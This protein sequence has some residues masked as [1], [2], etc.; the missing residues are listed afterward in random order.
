M[1]NKVKI[2]IVGPSE[3]G[4]TV[5]AN[6]LADATESA[7]GDYHPTQG[8]RILEFEVDNVNLGGNHAVNIEVEL[9]DCSGNQRFEICW[10]AMQKD[11]NGIIFVYNLDVSSHEKELEN[12]YLHFVKGKGIR[13]KLCHIFAH[14]KPAANPAGRAKLGGSLGRIQVTNTNLEEDPDAVRSSFQ[15]FLTQVISHVNDRR[16]QEELSIIE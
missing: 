14:Q 3:S 8:V 4:K 16:D 11:V 5:L 1:F 7:S 6:F 12:W 10:P 2:L 9:W 13:D 15:S